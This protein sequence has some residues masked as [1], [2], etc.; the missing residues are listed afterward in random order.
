MAVKEANSPIMPTPFRVA[1]KQPR[2]LDS[3][4]PTTRTSNATFKTVKHSLEA[5]EEDTKAKEEDTKVKEGTA[6]SK[7][8]EEEDTKAE[9]VDTKV[10]TNTLMRGAGTT[11]ILPTLSPKQ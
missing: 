2:E 6:V 5:E 10:P 4:S 8:K 3:T 9:G 7:A 1:L 11:A